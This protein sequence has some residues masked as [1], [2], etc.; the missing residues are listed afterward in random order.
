VPRKPPGLSRNPDTAPT[1]YL[2]HSKLSK[3]PSPFPVIEDFEIERELGRGGMGIVYKARQISTDQTVALKVIRKDRLQHD[4]AVRRFR[5]EAQAA[6]RLDHPNI[7]HVFDSDHSGDTHY[8]VME[9]VPGITIERFVEEKGPLAI[10]LAVDFMRQAAL[11][12]K[13][14][15]EQGLIHRDIKP[16]NLMVTPAC[17]TQAD[18]KPARLQVLDM[19]VARVLQLEG[20]PAESLSTLTQG[21]SVIGTADYVAP[22][23]LEDPHHADLRADLYSLGCTSYF[24]LAGDVPFPGGSLLSKLDKQRWE[25]PRPIN[26]KRAE[27]LPAVAEVVAKLMAKDPAER[28]QTA[29]QLVAALEELQRTGYVSHTPRGPQLREAA[30]WT[31][32]TGAVWTVAVAPGGQVV[33]SGG[34]DRVLR[35]WDLAKGNVLRTFPTQMQDIRAVAF[36]PKGDRFALGAGVSLRLGD[37]ATASEMRRFSGHSDAIRAVV[38]APDGRWLFSAGDDKTIRAWDVALGKEVQRLARHTGPVTGIAVTPAGHTLLSASRDQTIRWWDTLS[39]QEVRQVNPN[40]GAVLGLALAPEVGVVASAHFDTSI[41]LW[42]VDTG[43][44]LGQLHGHKQMVTALAFA[45]DGRTL[46]SAGQDHTIRWW[47]C[48]SGTEL[49]CLSIPRAGIHCLALTPDGKLGIAG[50][51]DLGLCLFEV[52]A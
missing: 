25:M 35:L 8:L 34:K 51:T 24:M 23:Q 47:N 49:S 50:C 39:A 11:G 4:E 7:V 41:R 36:A 17:G 12:L 22:E 42:D 9:Y 33:A 52:P 14:A 44:E 16:S 3:T 15:H 21:G 40:A 6:S 37:V 5:R 2:S 19:G 13:H 30:R 38:F 31:G 43:A 20:T 18:G 45:P 29:T 1:V 48:Q 28:Y 27:V 46:L 10:P 26:E 32:P